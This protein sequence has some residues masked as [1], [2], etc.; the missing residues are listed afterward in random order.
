MKYANDITELVGRTPLVRLNKVVKSGKNLVLAKLEQFNPCASVKDRA[1]IGMID[2]AEKRGQIK[3]GSVLI[4]ATSGNTGI[5][6]AFIAAVRN[7]KLIVTMPD[8]M[9]KERRDLLHIFGA[10]V[11]L[12]P[13]RKGMQGAVNRALALKKKIKGS[14]LVKQ[15]DNPANPR[16]H[17]MTTAQEI[18]YDTG[19]K[20]DV[21]ISGV[22]TGGTLTGVGRVL[23][24]HNPGV[25]IIAVEPSGSAVLSGGRAN[26]HEIQGIGAGFI[27]G[28]MDTSL[29]D[30]IIKVTDQEAYSAAKEMIQREGILA[31][32]SSGA[33]VAAVRKYLRKQKPKLE[34]IILIFPDN[35]ERY[36]GVARFKS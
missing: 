12:T 24:K 8:S 15:F 7:Y 14:F 31:G 33:V 2:A 19:G 35:G 18:I 32:I 28:V 4:E 23:K 36:L 29:V 34:T 21:V 20:V 22:G 11:E 26:P 25:K 1:A 3:P 17:E 16:I 5:A 6:L 13:A 30:E 9:S 10:R 27:P